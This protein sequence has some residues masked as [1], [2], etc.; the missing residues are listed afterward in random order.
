M[1]WTFRRRKKSLFFTRSRTLDLSAHN[2][3]T[4]PA[5]LSHLLVRLVQKL[6]SFKRQVKETG[7][8]NLLC[9]NSGNR[10]NCYSKLDVYGH[11]V[12]VV[13]CTMHGFEEHSFIT[14]SLRVS[15][16]HSPVMHVSVPSLHQQWLYF[17]VN[18]CLAVFC[19]HYKL[20]HFFTLLYIFLSG[21]ICNLI[22]EMC[23]VLICR[24]FPV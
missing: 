22:V 1:G 23:V 3:V 19:I 9:V 17:L 18:K 24:T 10:L 20:Y 11:H 13:L 6:V 15:C 21:L 12:T 7:G 2:L 8:S 4:V 16:D 5:A 14:N